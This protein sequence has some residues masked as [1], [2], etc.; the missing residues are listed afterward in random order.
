M[1]VGALLAISEARRPH[2]D[3]SFFPDHPDPV[4]DTY[5]VLMKR[6]DKAS[7]GKCFIIYTTVI[8]STSLEICS[9]ILITTHIALAG[10]IWQDFDFRI[11]TSVRRSHDQCSQYAESWRVY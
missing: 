2:F 6:Q 7:T 4:E 10:T 9:T 3:K 11:S 8:D 1:P 5:F